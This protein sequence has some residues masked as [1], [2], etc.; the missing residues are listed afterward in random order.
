M[1]PADRADAPA[2]VG[3]AADT[4]QV[5]EPFTLLRILCHEYDL[6][7]NL[8]K[9]V[10]EP[11]NKGPALIDKEVLFLSVGTPGLPPTRIT[12]DLWT[13]LTCFPS[14]FSDKPVEFLID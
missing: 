11:L 8:L 4:V 12:A 7:N 2:D 14:L 5:A 6:I 10:N 13:M 9:G 1:Q 3:N